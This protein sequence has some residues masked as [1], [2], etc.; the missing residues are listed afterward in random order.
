MYFA[1]FY[2]IVSMTFEFYAIKPVVNF[3]PFWGGGEGM[4]VESWGRGGWQWEWIEVLY[5]GL[6]NATIPHVFKS[7]VHDPQGSSDPCWGLS[8]G[9]RERRG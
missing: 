7:G 2:F 3:V 6:S 5:P 1:L 9:G 4:E 8:M